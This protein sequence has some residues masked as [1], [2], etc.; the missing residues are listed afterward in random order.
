MVG[1]IIRIA[2]LGTVDGI[3]L[4]A[5]LSL[6]QSS[7]WLALVC[8]ALATAG[9]NFVY[10]SK[11]TRASR[12]LLPGTVLLVI[13]QL[14]PIV[15]TVGTAFSNYSTENYV[16]RQDAIDG[17][18][19]SYVMQ[20]EGSPQYSI[21]VIHQGNTLGLL[22]TNPDSGIVSIGT[23]SAIKPVADPKFDSD[24]LPLAPAGWSVYT[25]DQLSDP[26][27][28]D[29]LLALSVPLANG[30]YIKVN[31]YTTAY[32][33]FSTVEYNAK[34]DQL[35]DTSDGYIFKEVEGKFIAE[36]GTPI[37]PGWRVNVGFK[38]FK[39]VVGDPAVRGPFLRVLVWNFVYAALSVVTT[40]LLGLALALLLNYPGLRGRKFLRSVFVV[41]YAIPGFL[42]LM[43]WAGF[44]NDDFGII[45]ATFGSHIPWLTDPYWAKVSAL[46]VNLWLGFPYMFFICT[47]ALQAIPAEYAEAA[48]VDGASPRQI[49]TK[50]KMP[51]LLAQLTPL[52][53]LS[54]SYNF[55]NFGG[56]YLLTGGGPAMNDS[57]IAGSTDI[58]ISYTYKLALGA[59]HGNDY[60]LACAIVIYI[61]A[62][63]A[64]ISLLGGRRMRAFEGMN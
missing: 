47:G 59:G 33:Y 52:L 54:F 60:G 63:V 37:L 39:S 9:L 10:M 20:V 49:M 4:W 11:R 56:I 62:I 61:F 30:E 35:I 26:T 23:A 7:N 50:I 12:W 44:L 31:D 2:V 19:K 5:G 34:K 18:L 57:D 3:A 64:P 38:N 46:L 29:A 40:F 8:L 55:N 6:L 22:L 53:I 15:F 1:K 14:Y 41:P 24:G 13:F 32:E 45:N 25:D 51:L 28:S 27:L 43:I 21:R 36:D 58:L 48:S 42:S 17:I 16:G